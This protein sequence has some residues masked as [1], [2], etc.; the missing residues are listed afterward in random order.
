MIDLAADPQSEKLF[1]RIHSYRGHLSVHYDTTDFLVKT[2]ETPMELIEVLRLRH[3]VFLREWQGQ[4]KFHGLDVEDFDFSSDHLMIIDKERGQVVGTYRLRAS[5]FTDQFYSQ[6]EFNLDQFLRWPVK[7]LEMGRA[8]THADFRT[9]QT[10]DLLWKGLVR[11][12][13]VSQSQFLFGC[14]SVKT[15]DPVLVAS[16]MAHFKQMGQYS[17]MYRIRPLEFYRHPD[18]SMEAARELTREELKEAL[19]SLLRSYLQ[20]GA[21]VYGEPAYD[22]EFACFDLLT[23]LDLDEITKRYEQRYFEG[24]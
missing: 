1:E 9:G 8:C 19:P 14:S 17:D 23:I 7:I 6:S 2:A 10:M 11:Y 18:F 13:K 15:S 20:A 16:L 21:K 24:G 3:E 22:R 12:I 4:E 5:V